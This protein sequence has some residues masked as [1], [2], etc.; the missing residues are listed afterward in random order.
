MDLFFIDAL[1][2]FEWTVYAIRFYVK[3]VCHDSSLSRNLVLKQVVDM[4]S[5]FYHML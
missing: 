1:I 5:N 3:N 2:P 4:S